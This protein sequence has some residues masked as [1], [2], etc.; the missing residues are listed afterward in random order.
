MRKTRLLLV[1]LFALLVAAFA[2]P[3]FAAPLSGAI[4]TTDST[5]TGTNVNIFGSKDDV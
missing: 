1:G 3:A 2:V 5:C 4:F